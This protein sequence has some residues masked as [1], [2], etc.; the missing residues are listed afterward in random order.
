MAPRRAESIR[1][2]SQSKS[3]GI[4]TVTK[5]EKSKKTAEESDDFSESDQTTQL[6]TSQ[7]TLN[8]PHFVVVKSEEKDQKVS[9]LSPFAI[10]MCIQSIKGLPKSIKRLKYGDLLL[11]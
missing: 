9:D 6:P 1:D 11:E 4:Q 10:E 2:E 8:I 3:W 7:P 5:T